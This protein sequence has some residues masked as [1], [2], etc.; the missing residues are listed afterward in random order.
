MHPL[1]CFFSP[2]CGLA[3]S[4]VQYTYD[5]AGNRLTQTVVYDEPDRSS[6]GDS[7]NG[8]TL[9]RE[10]AG[11]TVS[12]TVSPETGEVCVEVLGL[13]SDADCRLSVYALSGICVLSQSVTDTRTTLDLGESQD[14]IYILLLRLNGT[15]ASWKIT[16]K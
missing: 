16:M 6:K 2:F 10:V 7:R 14:N 15:S 12:V 3:Q 8:N 5:N 13:D 4:R 11:H 9:T 1:H